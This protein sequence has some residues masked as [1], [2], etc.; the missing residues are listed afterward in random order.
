MDRTCP[1][2][3]GLVTLLLALA[4][5]CA[6]A[7]GA[8]PGQPLDLLAGSQRFCLPNGLILLIKEDHRLPVLTSTLV[9]KV[10][11]TDDPEGQSGM[12]HYLEHM[13]FKG[14]QRYHRGDIDRI[15]LRS[16][17][18][19]NAYTTFD[20]TAYY[21]HVDSSHLDDVLEILSDTMGRCTFDEKEF[22]VERGPILQEMSIWL[23]GPWGGLERELDQA[24]Y[25][26]NR[27][28]HPILGSRSDVEDMSRDRM[29]AHYREHY[30]PEKAVLVLVGDVRT[31]E[32]CQKAERC[33]GSIPRGK[34]P[35]SSGV[36]EPPQAA[37]RCVTTA[38]SLSSD[39]FIMAFRGG[40]EGSSHAL[41]LDLIATLLGE[42]RYSKLSTRLV[43]ELEL[44]SEE[45]ISV[46]NEPRRSDG[47]FSI[48]VALGQ[49]S[50]SDQARRAV[51]EVLGDLSSWPVS[52]RELR[53]AK[54]L[55][56]TRLAFDLG[57]QTELALRLGVHEA[58]GFPGF[59]GAYMD[60]IEAVSAEEVKKVAQETF[61]PANRTLVLGPGSGRSPIRR[62]RCLR[63]SGG[64][65]AR[66]SPGGVAGAGFLPSLPE[67]REERLGNGLTLLAQRRS[68][69]PIVTLQ[70]DL[71]AG[72]LYEPDDKAGL[73]ELVARMLDQGIEGREGGT[74]SSDEFAR[75]IE[76]LGGNY[77]ISVAGVTVH[78]MSAHVTTGMD[79]LRDFLRSPSFPEDRLQKTREDQLADL[80]STDEEPQDAARRLFFESAYRGHPYARRTLG[81]KE[82][83]ARLTR[84]DVLSFYHSYYRP[85][86]LVLAV[87]GDVDPDRVLRDLRRHFE[88]WKGEGPWGPPRI[89]P[90]V[91][92]IEPRTIHH[93]SKAQQIR[94]HLGHVG[95]DRFHPDYFALRVMETILGSSPGF[96][97]RLARR[98]RDELGLTYDV[99]GTITEGADLAAAPFQVILGVDEKNQKR[100]V[101][102]V[103]GVLRTF[104]NEGPTEEELADAKQYLLGSFANSWETVEDTAA[105][106]VHAGRFGLGSDY[107]AHFQAAISA[108]T[109]EDVLRVAREQIDLDALT[110]VVVGG[111]SPWTPVTAGLLGAGLVLGWIGLRRRLRRRVRSALAGAEGKGVGLLRDPGSL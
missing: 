87:V 9:Y 53:R 12:A 6:G 69:L 47:L 60:R 111:R 62:P 49:D 73:A 34:A 51:E 31:E 80:E 86:N 76:F 2:V 11:S 10:G 26:R 43:T 71:R 13:V 88:S 38:T 65:L 55:I 99:S 64:G 68:D 67:V 74:R 97:N 45:G 92:Q 27:Y 5:G 66:L 100:A 35:P 52:D 107:P 90:A 89:A 8:G 108:V 14:T 72:A 77:S 110:T 81:R 40:A 109:R 58:L 78:L 16:G 63:T 50:S 85:E 61:I 75:E 56:R 30:T 44:S 21:F 18:E 84:E 33:F 15:T 4:A 106:L 46:V 102:E 54:N 19:N 83:V 1:S 79:L 39:R 3:R 22:Q 48:Q 91:R 103:L 57:S 32:A 24:V 36:V 104:R 105:Y 23:D 59:L 29:V 93:A 28:G 96:T 95:V 17:G 98:V 7:P 37:P 20:T 25:A 42:G 94:I 41:A 70:A 101:Q 82:T